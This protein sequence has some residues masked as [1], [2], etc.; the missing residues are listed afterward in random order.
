[1]KA[2]RLACAV[3][4]A[5]ALAACGGDNVPREAQPADT[6]AV[7][8]GGSVVPGGDRPGVQDEP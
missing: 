6:V 4:A 1:M 8:P 5:S 3:L 7:A 2:I